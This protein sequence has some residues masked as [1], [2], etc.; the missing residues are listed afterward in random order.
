MTN[1]RISSPRV[2]SVRPM[3]AIVRRTTADGTGVSALRGGRPG[4]PVAGP[5]YTLAVIAPRSPEQSLALS[6]TFGRPFACS[7]DSPRSRAPISTSRSGEIVLLSRRRTARARPRCCGCARGCC[8]CASGEAEVL[9]VDLAVDRRRDA[10]RARARRPRDVL[11]RRS[12]RR[13]RTSASRPAPPVTRPPTPT[14]RS[15]GSALQ[16]VAD[17]AHGRLSQGSGAGVV[18]RDRARPRPAAAAARR[19]ARRARRAGPRGARRGR[20]RRARRRAHGAA[21]V[22]RARP[23]PAARDARGADRRPG[24]CTRCR[25]RR[26]TAS[27]TSQP[28]ARRS[29]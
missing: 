16:R 18:A 8:R 15:N 21:G 9:G 24:R 7:D 20:A 3:A 27:P 6:C 12:H 13:A 11:L 10:A 26:P 1:S 25:R 2:T 17:V 28:S 23:R 14:P 29:A 22:A 4:S 5:S 19:A